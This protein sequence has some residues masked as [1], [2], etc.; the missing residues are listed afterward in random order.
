[1]SDYAINLLKAIETGD[2]EHMN[3]A[4]GDAMQAKIA[5]ALDAKK[6]EVAQSIYGGGVEQESSDEEIPSDG[7]QDNTVS[8]SEE[9][10]TEEV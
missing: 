2:Q 3:A 1:M 9:D 4:F 10:G 7:E 5:D 6:I 8:T